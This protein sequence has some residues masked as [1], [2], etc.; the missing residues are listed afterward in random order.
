LIGSNTSGVNGDALFWD[1][2]AWTR[3]E[4]AQ[5]FAASR[6]LSTG[7]T[8]LTT[9]GGIGTHE[10]KV[11]NYDSM[12]QAFSLS[13]T[14]TVSGVTGELW[15]I[16]VPE[17]GRQDIAIATSFTSNKLVPLSLSLGSWSVGTLVSSSNFAQPLK[18]VIMPLIT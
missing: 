18:S 10:I 11:L 6:W 15:G 4:V 3:A 1:G 7:T 12:S 14:L 17:L 8:V 16:S 5:V 9:S 2:S 13:Q